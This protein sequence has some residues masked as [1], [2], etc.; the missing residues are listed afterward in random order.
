MRREYDFSDAVRGVTARRYAEGVESHAN[1]P[2]HPSRRSDGRATSEVANG[3]RATT[4]SAV[5][6]TD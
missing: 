4:N 5:H 3:S 2:S 6:P 1:V